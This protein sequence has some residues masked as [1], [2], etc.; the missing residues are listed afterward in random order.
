MR[1]SYSAAKLFAEC[2]AR[3][4]AERI[5]KVPVERPLHMLTGVFLHDVTDQ[6]VKHLLAEQV[7]HDLTA[8]ARIF[9]TAW[10]QRRKSEIPEAMFEELYQVW[11]YIKDEL[12]LRDYLEVVGSEVQ[13]ALRRDWTP[14]AWDAEDAWLR[15]KLDMLKIDGSW[16]VK[17]W[18]LKTGYK[19]EDADESLQLRL[20][21]ALVLAA[22][23]KAQEVTVSLYYPRLGVRRSHVLKE[24]EI[25][26]ARR[27]IEAI[28]AQIATSDYRATPGA[29]CMDCPI[30]ESCE[31]RKRKPGAA[32]PHTNSE[33]VAVMDHL[34]FI[35]RE[36]K[37][38]QERIK[39]WIAVNG[40]VESNGM[41]AGYST[42]HKYQYPLPAMRGLFERKGIDIFKVLKVDSD[43]LEKVC[44]RDEE[45]QKE[46]GAIVIDKSSSTFK[47]KKAEAA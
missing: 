21:G 6:Y 27:W 13:I 12:V 41:M 22:L 11:N 32:A 38:M 43:L 7:A 4:K 28:D 29:A 2:P 9:S 31:A 1:I 37:E 10:S 30:F 46:V 23:P 14:T 42:A 3:F 39:L 5:D 47:I 40:P 8:A 35:E 25:N 33:A 24:G 17:V 20:Y 44:R 19:V 15:G 34:I 45:L 36:R 18:D 16:H 26:E